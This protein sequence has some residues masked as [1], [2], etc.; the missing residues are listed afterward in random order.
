MLC[1]G[2][3]VTGEARSSDRFVDVPQ[4]DWSENYIYRLRELDI[5]A[6]RTRSVFGYNEKTTRAEFVTFL[7]RASNI[8][9][10][11]L[12]KAT[13]F[14]D[15]KSYDWFVPYI[16]AGIYANIIKQEDYLDGFFKPN[17]FITREEMAVMIVRALGYETLGKQLDKQPSSFEDVHR[18]I[19]HISIAKD[20]GIINGKSPT[21]FAPEDYAL[22]QEAAAMLIRMYDVI[23]HQLSTLNGF[24]AI[25]SYH[26]IDTVTTFN[27][28]SFGWS[29]IGYDEDKDKLVFDTQSPTSA[30]PFYMPSG[31]H[32]V[33]EKVVDEG[34]KRY[35]SV[36]ATNG[37]IIEKDDDKIG[38]VSYL[39]RDEM[40]R[41]EMTKTVASQVYY[42]N[43]ENI[44]I[45]YDGIVIDF[46]EIRDTEQDKEHFVAFLKNV[47]SYLE[48][49]HKELIVC[50]HPKREEGEAYYNG[51]DYKA[52]GEIADKV[53]LMA[54]DY[55]PSQIRENEVEIFI[56]TTPLA[57]IKDV[58]T[59]LKSAID[60]KNGIPKE[61]LLLQI[62]FDTRQWQFEDVKLV[63]RTA[64]RPTYDM[65][66][67]RMQS[68]KNNQSANIHYSNISQAPRFIFTD[69]HTGIRNVLW[70]EDE[71]SIQAK[72]ELAKMFGI[73]G[74]SVWRLG[75][76]PDI[77]PKDDQEEAFYLDVMKL[78][79][80]SF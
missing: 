13:V 29:S 38:T 64:A 5:T 9:K 35:L 78:L 59:A 51:Y 56:G 24:Y 16:N 50:V 65:L 66:A 74:I 26:Q 54:H 22:R 18:Y 57:P 77:K 79:E 21:R 43:Q 15:V 30:H 44:E 33:V 76:I 31:Y 70:Y 72:I 52:I 32:E 10:K 60:P 71:R 4:G 39:L 23:N 27:M 14:K 37:D 68:E 49:L 40:Q 41:E 62:C 6:G 25:H 55:A 8:E 53:I 34:A 19:G 67:R 46:E 7:I 58:Y 17:H 45:E 61:K 20:F 75:L 3:N 42:P 80:N 11:Q 63:Q 36:F 48:P 73:E 69:E 28:I 47:K 2:L 1:I 12:G